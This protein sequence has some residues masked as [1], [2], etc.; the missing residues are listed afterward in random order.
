VAPWFSPQP[1]RGVSPLP[2]TPPPPSLPF[3]FPC[4]APAPKTLRN[5]IGANHL[6]PV[7]LPPIEDPRLARY[8][9]AWFSAY[10]RPSGCMLSAIL[11]GLSVHLL[12]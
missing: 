12:T 1:A 7:L 2:A 3:P 8:T 9:A 4:Q 6:E 11:H 10:V 5:Q